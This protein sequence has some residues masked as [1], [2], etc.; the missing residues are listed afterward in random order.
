MVA[1]KE[2]PPPKYR[3]EGLGSRNPLTGDMSPVTDAQLATIKA[4][5]DKYGISMSATSSR[6]LKD[7]SSLEFINTKG[8]PKLRPKDLMSNELRTVPDFLES[9]YKVNG[10]KVKLDLAKTAN[11]VSMLGLITGNTFKLIS[12]NYTTLD[13]VYFPGSIKQEGGDW[14]SDNAT[15]MAQKFPEQDPAKTDD[16][17][18]SGVNGPLKPLTPVHE[19][20]HRGLNQL[21]TAFPYDKVLETEGEDVARVLYDPSVEHVLIEAILQSRGH[22]ETDKYRY[23]DSTG[24][25]DASLQKVYRSITP[26]F[27]LSN[28][29]LEERGY[30][31]EQVMAE[32]A[33]EE[34]GRMNSYGKDVGQPSLWDKFK[35]KLGFATGGLA[36]EEA[37]RSNS[38]SRQMEMALASGSNDVD[39]VSG[40][41]VP[42]GSLPEEV[43]DDID[44]R[45]SEGEYVVPADVVRFFGVAF[46][47]DLR[48][49]AKMGLAKMESEG[50]IGG[51]PVSDESMPMDVASAKPEG[52][53]DEDIASLE[54][55]LT[56]GVYE[57]GL[58]DKVALVAKNDSMVN[59]RM[60][61]KGF[62]VGGLTGE[63]KDSQYS[64]P[65]KI[66]SIIDRFMVT[67][68]QNPELMQQLTQRGIT[69]NTNSANNTPQQI[70]SATNDVRSQTAQAFAHGGST[71]SDATT[72]IGFGSNSNPLE[73]DEGFNFGNFG[74]GFSAFGSPGGGGSVNP[75][76]PIMMDY[77]NPSTGK[78]MKIPHDPTSNQP[79][80][81][82]PTG[83]VLG[84]P[85]EIN[86][87][88]IARVDRDGRGQRQ[89]DYESD[90][91][92]GHMKDYDYKTPD[93]LFE[94]TQ[95][96][97]KEGVRDYKDTG[98]GKIDKFSNLT[99]DW[100][101]RHNLRTETLAN[102]Q[103]LEGIEGFPKE[104]IDILKETVKNLEKDMSAASITWSNLQVR[105]VAEATNKELGIN[106]DQYGITP[107]VNA[108][109]YET[110]LLFN[111]AT[112]YVDTLLAKKD[113]PIADPASVTRVKSKRGKTPVFKVTNNDGEGGGYTETASTPDTYSPVGG[114]PDDGNDRR[115][116]PRTVDG[117]ETY[118]SKA[119]RG[120]G[121]NKGGLMKKKTKK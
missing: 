95:A 44:A 117:K 30:N 106:G 58:M 82:V 68:Q 18:F 15:F 89:E 113:K 2:S 110:F 14:N 57:G 87:A 85:P 34:A 62:A 13:G 90:K 115:G 100:N 61:A 91:M 79:T 9:Q 102:I 77:Y 20:I 29:L 97:A 83:F 78:T 66:D 101:Q 23:R 111:G 49:K 93:G 54:Q 114:R 88:P 65:T 104:K 19:V 33:E 103:M 52:I 71:H 56:T 36:T 53:S 84:V 69:I 121:F 80:S 81:A 119:K 86:P 94:S 41:E 75:M 27:K 24:L 8:K 37:P 32:L 11:P 47:E 112:N 109:G 38:M 72:P 73:T 60:K 76:E 26:I 5:E 70:K 4:I 28:S 42:P 51:E 46:L 107:K 96:R 45:L 6:R 108:S 40:N 99:N 98:F 74:L 25:T 48:M 120:G 67:A 3:P 7:G 63:P 10:E 22:Q 92:V 16:I 50:R 43:R 17:A 64:D 118:S 39:P 35:T 31:P 1:P 21:R 105:G 12:E 59:S 55:A 116:A